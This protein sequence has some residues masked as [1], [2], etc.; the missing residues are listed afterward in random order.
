MDNRKT[1]LSIIHEKS[2]TCIFEDVGNLTK[3][4]V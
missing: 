1:G 4:N 3:I 2:E